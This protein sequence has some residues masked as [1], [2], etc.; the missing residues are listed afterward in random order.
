MRTKPQRIE[1]FINVRV[2]IDILDNRES[3][4]VACINILIIILSSLKVSSSQMCDHKKENIKKVTRNELKM[5][6]Y[7]YMR[8]LSN[9]KNNFRN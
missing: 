7:N 3:K 4:I 5:R 2:T 1:V 6:T 9:V 8:H